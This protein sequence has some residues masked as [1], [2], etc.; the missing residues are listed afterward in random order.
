MNSILYLYTHNIKCKLVFLIY[1]I[2]SLSS[3]TTR[4]I[5]LHVQAIYI[6]DDP[7]VGIE[8]LEEHYICKRLHKG[9]LTGAISP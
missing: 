1:Y 7:S 2:P 5:V 8:C 4:I 3:V 6:L 9:K